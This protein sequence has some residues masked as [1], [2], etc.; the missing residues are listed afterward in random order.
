[1]PDSPLARLFA[2]LEGPLARE[3]LIAYRPPGGADEDALATYLWNA[4][5]SEAFYPA[6]QGVEMALRNAVHAAGMDTFGDDALWFDTPAI[7]PLQQRERDMVLAARRALQQHHK[8]PTAGRLIAELNFGF[9]VG[10]FN[11]PYERVLWAPPALGLL[12]TAFPHVPR[13]HRS[14]RRLFQRLDRIRRL[15]NRVFYY[16]PIWAWTVPGVSSLG[17]QHREI[18]ETIGWI[19]PPLRETIAR[20]DRFPDVYQRDRAPYRH[21]LADVARTL[22]S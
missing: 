1:M 9:W 20:L 8:P 12:D 4:A 10:L 19:S 13:R 5:L 21:V 2:L 17:D 15:R 7:L 11:A 18:V 6:L 14:R 16:E 22:S 3:R